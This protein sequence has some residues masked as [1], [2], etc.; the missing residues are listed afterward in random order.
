MVGGSELVLGRPSDHDNV[1]STDF[2]SDRK[3][4]GYVQANPAIPVLSV[5][6]NAPNPDIS[7]I[8]LQRTC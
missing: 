7:L 8:S 6:M 1:K 3:F 4:I 2:T 5:F